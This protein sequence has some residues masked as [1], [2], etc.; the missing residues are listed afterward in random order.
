[1]SRERTNLMVD[2]QLSRSCEKMHRLL[3]ERG[4]DNWKHV[5]S[6]SNFENSTGIFF[7]AKSLLM[8]ILHVTRMSLCLLLDVKTVG[9]FFFNHT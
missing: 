7:N 5:Y 2:E 9:Y 3:N 4:K 6:I 8:F 1:M